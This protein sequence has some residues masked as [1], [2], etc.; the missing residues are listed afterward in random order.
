MI[1][2]E[3]DIEIVTLGRRVAGWVVVTLKLSESRDDFIAIPV[4]LGDLR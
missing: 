3:L 4:E 2:R 1:L